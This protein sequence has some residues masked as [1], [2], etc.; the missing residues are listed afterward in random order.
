MTVLGLALLSLHA[1]EPGMNL[2]RQAVSSVETQDPVVALTFDACAT[3]AQANGFDRAVFDILKRE[4]I[5]ATVFLTGRWIEFHPA[6]A[7]ELA[8]EPRIELGNHSYSHPILTGI[9]A[10]R[11]S[12]E[13]ARTESLIA[14]LGRRSVALRPPAGVWNPRVVQAGLSRGLPTLLWDVVSGDAGGH[15][16]APIM[17]QEV[18]QK[19]RPGSVVIFHINGR[20]PYTKDALPEIIH[21]LRARGFRFVHVSELL[22]TPGA[23]SQPARRMMVRK[24]KAKE[25]AHPAG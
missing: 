9:S 10:E 14:D 7:R 23:H 16:P 22:A 20:G 13:V 17:V 19:V 11:L 15:V 12:E 24:S 5:P 1:A 4:E 21:T 18:I 6:E 8:A 2:A 25:R 3:S